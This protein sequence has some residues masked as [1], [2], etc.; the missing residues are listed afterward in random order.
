MNI[1]Q[2]PEHSKNQPE[3]LSFF[4]KAGWAIGEL[5]LAVYVGLSMAFMLF[6]CTDVLHIPPAMAGISLLIPRILDA[7][8]DPVMGAIS[9]RTVSQF[10]RRRLYLL[11]GAPFLGLTFAAVFFIPPH[12]TLVLKIVALVFLSLLS[13]VAVTIFGVP[14]SAMAAEMTASYGERT[15][16]I[17]YKMIAARTGIILAGFLGPLIFRSV[18]D[19]SQGFRLLG[20]IAGVF[21]AGT[22]LW[23]FFAT[24]NAP[25]I[26]RPVQKFNFRAEISAVASNG[27]LRILWLV[28]LVQNI[29]IGAS[30][31]TLIYFLV[32][33]VG[34][35]SRQTAIF[36]TAAG[37]AATIAT[38][39]WVRTAR[40][41]GKKHAYIAGLLLAGI[42]ASILFFAPS[43]LP[44]LLVIV[45]VAGAIDGGNQLLP[46]AMVPD[47][48][49][50]D[51]AA[52]GERREGVIFGAWSFCLKL[53]MT[54][55]A[56]AVSIGLS[57]SGFNGAAT[58]GQ[59][60]ET[61]LGIRFMYAGFPAILWFAATFLLLRYP[62][63]EMAFAALKAKAAARRD[64]S[65]FET[66]TGSI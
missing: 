32:H 59:S 45:V 64:K 53:G 56:F 4:I 13:N 42:I 65:L 61:I 39:V 21:M 36:L 11:L 23:A 6:Y 60:P 46:N 47:T 38:P 16:L 17:G 57:L 7:F 62:L 31:T 63:T 22:G 43:I 5:A 40:T 48:V 12:A 35:D 29:A 18:E 19:I 24:A 20:E 44:L 25:Q 58:G 27:P 41:L 28:F 66:T 2:L 50:V 51:E 9:D 10:G 15:N 8:A 3:R 14:Y 54:L 37:V 52:T 1:D 30:A 49:E 33:A 26:A 34:V 55:G